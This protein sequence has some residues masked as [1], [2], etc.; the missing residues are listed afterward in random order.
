M[1]KELYEFT[2]EM[3]GNKI[4]IDTEELILQHKLD[5]ECHFHEMQ[6]EVLDKYQLTEKT[7]KITHS[8]GI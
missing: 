5:E 6:D 7:M 2:V 4:F 3:L 1:G 8:L